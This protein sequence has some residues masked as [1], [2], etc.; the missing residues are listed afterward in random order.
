[1]KF[2]MEFDCDNAAF[3]EDHRLE[4][5]EILEGVGIA[6]DSR[7][8]GTIRDSNGNRVGRWEITE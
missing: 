2:T 6:V 7:D 1:M 8:S 4:I 5:Q 3:E